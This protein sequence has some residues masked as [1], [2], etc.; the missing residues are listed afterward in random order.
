MTV[1]IILDFEN[2]SGEGFG[3]KGEYQEIYIK[4]DVNTKTGY[5]I[6]LECT[7]TAN[8]MASIALYKYDGMMAQSISETLTG[9]FIKS[10]M[11]I[12]LDIYKNSFTTQITSPDIDKP[13]KLASK[14][15]GNLYSGMGIKH[16]AIS[17]EKNRIGV[18]HIEMSFPE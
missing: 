10:S 9:S 6:R 16:H 4:Y 13:L 7:D 11:D 1:Y 5:G 12:R 18:R 3:N 8:H 14:I 17:V 15:T 2:N